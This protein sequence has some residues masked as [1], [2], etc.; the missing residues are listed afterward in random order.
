M[1]IRRHNIGIK[2]DF[3]K[4]IP[5]IQVNIIFRVLIIF[6]VTALISALFKYIKTQKSTENLEQKKGMAKK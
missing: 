1:R 5:E 2:A 6:L 4:Q 3:C